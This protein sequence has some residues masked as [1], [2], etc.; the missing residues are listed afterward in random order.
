MTAVT[1]TYDEDTEEWTEDSTASSD[2]Y[3]Y[4]SVSTREDDGTLTDNLT[5]RWANA[6]T[7]N[8]SYFVWIPRYAYRITYYESETSTEATGYYDG[9][10]MWNAEDGTVKYA[11][12]DGI[13]T[14]TYNGN[15]YIVHPAFCDGTDNNYSNGEWDEDLEGFWF[16]K[17]EMYGTS[18]SALTSIP[19]TASTRTVV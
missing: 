10:G 8:G 19:N 7:E 17:Y 11:L 18:S 12:D 14:V 4:T 1:W 15:K 9:W 5:S 2:W 6:K 13:E 3:S 16:A